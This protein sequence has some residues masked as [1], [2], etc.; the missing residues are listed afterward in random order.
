MLIIYKDSVSTS[1]RKE[2]LYCKEETIN[3]V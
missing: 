1:Q 3:A 2:C